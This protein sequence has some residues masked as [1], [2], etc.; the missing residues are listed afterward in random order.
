VSTHILLTTD[1]SR[2]TTMLSFPNCKINIGLNIVSRRPDGYHNLETVFY[3]VPLTD[4]LELIR[5]DTRL[6]TGVRF[7]QTG[8]I[9]AGNP[10]DNLCVKAWQ[11]LKKEYPE[12]PAV[13]MHLHKVIPMGAGLGGGSADGAFALQLLNRFFQLDIPE[14]KL[15]ALA[16]QLGSDCPFFIHNRP[17]FATG[18]GEN[19]EP[20]PL[21]LSKYRIVLVNPGIHI[22]TAQAFTGI[23]PQTAALALK[24]A[25]SQPLTAWKD[26]IV[27]DFESTVFPLFPALK[28]IKEELYRQGALYA[29]LTGTGS[30]LYG[31]FPKVV[32]TSFPFPSVWSVYTV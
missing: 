23:R 17:A 11:L 6:E 9:V 3:P 21:N 32:L 4:A 20:I 30:T 15:A 28:E 25:I 27:N 14:E 31:I 18:R 5:S 12:L 22:S 10:A 1:N 24:T 13:E 19:L 16:L 26:S 8:L 2:L 7:T 29:S